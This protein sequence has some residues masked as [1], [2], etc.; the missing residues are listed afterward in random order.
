MQS[1]AEPYLRKLL[2]AVIPAYQTASGLLAMVVL[3]RSLVAYEEI[4][5]VT[6]WQSAAHM[7]KFCESSPATSHSGVL[8][9]REPPQLYQVV[10]DA[11]HTDEA[12]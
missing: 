7:Q 1:H 10:F 3:R 8:P 4:A 11:F 2:D 9:P 5:T 12:E 6:T